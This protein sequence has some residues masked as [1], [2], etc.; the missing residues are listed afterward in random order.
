MFSR[1]E[2]F[3]LQGYFSTGMPAMLHLYRLPDFRGHSLPP[4]KNITKAILFVNITP[5]D[6]ECQ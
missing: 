2:N 5:S 4:E 6:A 3:G 1:I